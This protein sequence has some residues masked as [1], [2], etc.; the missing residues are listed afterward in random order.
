[1]EEVSLNRS[2]TCGELSSR[3]REQSAG[4]HFGSQTGVDT[5]DQQSSCGGRDFGTD[6]PGKKQT[7][8]KGEAFLGIRKTVVERISADPSSSQGETGENICTG[9]YPVC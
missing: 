2:L 1:M 8:R 9:Q 6:Q 5:E 7:G 3:R 4:G